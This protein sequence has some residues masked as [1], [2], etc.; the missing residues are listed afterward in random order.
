MIELQRCC[1]WASVSRGAP[2]SLDKQMVTYK[3]PYLAVPPVIL[4]SETTEHVSV[5]E[6]SN[7]TLK[8]AA[9]GHPPPTITWTREDNGYITPKGDEKGA[10]RSS[11][12]E[13]SWITFW[14]ST[15]SQSGIILNY[16]AAL[17]YNG[18]ELLLERV[19]RAGK[20]SLFKQ[21]SPQISKCW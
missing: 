14:N 17:S 5:R 21:L 9:S 19:G 10:L 8:C 11:W 12:N 3:L 1:W 4:P 16:C 13:N 15:V 20:R 2:F 7:V 18:S 6:A